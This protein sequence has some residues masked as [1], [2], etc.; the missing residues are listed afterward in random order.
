M[1]VV[2]KT[3]VIDVDGQKSFRT[4][5]NLN[6]AVML[7]YWFLKQKYY[8]TREY[9]GYTDIIHITAEKINDNNPSV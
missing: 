7:R 1:V 6:S 5:D 3:D 8:N 9:F 4:E 2:W